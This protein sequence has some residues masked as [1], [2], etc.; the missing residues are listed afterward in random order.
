LQAKHMSV[1]LSFLFW[2]LKS[3]AG[4]DMMDLDIRYLV[5]GDNFLPL[6]FEVAEQLC[7][8]NILGS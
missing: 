2:R 5:R 4:R 7:E 6:L 3:E 8:Q 1:T